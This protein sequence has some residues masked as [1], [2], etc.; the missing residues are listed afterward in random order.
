MAKML[1]RLSWIRGICLFAIVWLGIALV[2]PSAHAADAYVARYLQV[3]EPISLER[4]DQ[5]NLRSFSL[6]EL[7]AGKK[8]FEQNCLSC[9]VGGATLPDPSVPLSL[10]ALQG[11]IP[12]R[13]T[14]N[15][16]VAYLRHPMT[17]DGSEETFSCRKVSENWLAQAEIETL[18]GFVLRAAQKAPGWGTDQF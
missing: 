4:D 8:L 5:G 1:N 17:Y 10:K 11:A 6:Q 15:S 16:L 3:T 2:S 13:D 7:T 14:I 18:A 12:P 9:H